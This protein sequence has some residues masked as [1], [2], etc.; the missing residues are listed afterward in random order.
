MNQ[1]DF[2]QGATILADAED[3]LIGKTLDNTCSVERQC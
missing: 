3:E 1:V 2:W